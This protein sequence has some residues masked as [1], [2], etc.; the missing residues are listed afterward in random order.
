MEENEMLYIDTE[1]LI[2]YVVEKTGIDIEVV[3]QVVDAE[4][5]F[6]IEKGIA[7]IVEE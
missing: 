3:R 5:D 6:Y 1:E 7:E 2:S 4:S